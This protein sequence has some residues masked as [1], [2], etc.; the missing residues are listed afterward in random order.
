MNLYVKF[1]NAAKYFG[2]VDF[3]NYNNLSSISYGAGTIVVEYASDGYRDTIHLEF[4]E[5]FEAT[6]R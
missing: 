1:N 4:V 6:A 2:Y 5:M 3:A